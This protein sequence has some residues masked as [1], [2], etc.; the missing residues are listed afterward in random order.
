[1]EYMYFGVW[2]CFEHR[3]NTIAIKDNRSVEIKA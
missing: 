1:M 3:E 2:V